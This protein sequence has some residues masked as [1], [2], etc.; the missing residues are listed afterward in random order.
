MTIPRGL[1][2][3]MAVSLD[4]L[5]RE[6]QVAREQALVGDYDA[7]ERG[8]ADVMMRLANRADEVIDPYVQ[9]SLVSCRR[10]IGE[11][12][13]LVQA[14]KRECTA[15]AKAV[16]PVAAAGLREPRREPER[17]PPTSLID[18]F[19]A[20][21]RPGADAFGRAGGGTPER[22]GM[23]PFARGPPPEDPDV[24][25]PPSRLDYCAQARI[26][27]LATLCEY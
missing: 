3:T 27:R 25:P 16:P 12:L 8:F 19:E 21:A 11:E 20:E 7:A 18:R 2:G 24:W 23:S 22:G 13:G 6:L 17:D 26:P 15:A 5:P 10:D 9:S 1:A 4:R 14:L